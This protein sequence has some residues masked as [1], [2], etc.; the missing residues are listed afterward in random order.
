MNDSD[1]PLSQQFIPTKLA[2]KILG[3]TS[4]TL[5]NWD[6]S[7]KISTVRTTSNQRLYNKQDI[8]NLTRCN[9]PSVQKRKIAYCRVSSSKQKNDLTRQ[10]NFFKTNY[11][12]FE[13][14]SDVGPG[15]NWKRKGLLSILDAALSGNLSEVMVAHKD[16][17]C[18]FSFE[19]LEFIFTRSNIKLTLLDQED[20]QSNSRE[21]SDDIM[22]IIHVYSGRKMG[23]RRY[24]NQKDLLVSKSDTEEETKNVDG[25]ES[26]CV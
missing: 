24:K 13:L 8:L 5:R 11:P 6:S 15:L 3:V 1:I 26:V 9:I 12:T 25:D 20:H 7:G 2:R 23:K 21:L 14:V 16:R 17:L 22:S 4:D 10:E 19:L 18:R